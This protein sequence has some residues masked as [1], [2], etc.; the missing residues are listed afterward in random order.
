[1][2]PIFQ[3][4]PCGAP[5][6]LGRVVRDLYPVE[7]PTGTPLSQLQELVDSLLE[8][9]SHTY[10]RLDASASN[11]DRIPPL[12]RVDT[13]A[14]Y[15]DCESTAGL[16]TLAKKTCMLIPQDP[17]LLSKLCSRAG[18]SGPMG[19]APNPA[20]P[21]QSQCEGW[22]LFDS[23]TPR[24]WELMARF[25]T[26]GNAMLESGQLRIMTTVGLATNASAA[27][28]K[29]DNASY[30]GHCFNVGFLDTPNMDRPIA[31]ILE[32]TAPKIDVK[33]T[34]TS[35]R[36][37]ARVCKTLAGKKITAS[38]DGWET[39]TLTMSDFATALGRQVLEMTRILNA[40]N[41]GRPQEGGWPT[42]GKIQGWL[43]STMVMNSLDSD[44]DTEL[45]FYH[46]IMYAGW[47]CTETGLGCMP[48]EEPGTAANLGNN[49]TN[50]FQQALKAGCHPYSLHNMDIRGFDGGIPPEKIRMM[51]QIMNE[52]M[53]PMA[54]DSVFQQL[55]NYWIPC[56]SLED[57]NVRETAM[58]EKGIDY[59]RVSAMET[60]SV[61]EFVPI[62]LEAKRQLINRANQINMAH[63]NS[64]GIIGSVVALGTGVHCFL[65][66]P[67]RDI[68]QLTYLDSLRQALEELNW[69]GF[70]K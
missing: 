58:R 22:P 53:P 61:P 29:A 57:I 4:L 10:R 28:V 18:P 49:P 8:G 42:K 32:G 7:V 11:H 60:P 37:T 52:A 9:S 5:Q 20:N 59:L 12:T 50:D 16:A 17:D 35:P 68:K 66:I 23:Y 41:G 63:P 45:R 33:V 44:P 69:P 2:L 65:D 38:G 40:P 3:A 31:F 19:I 6:F 26:R 36:V 47:P 13:G 34:A 46:R 1:L 43:A 24:D 21:V 67:Q 70:K 30:N 55:A 14:L 39:E 62:I 56:E 51:S 25:F 54:D 15:D 27:D 64:D 48:V